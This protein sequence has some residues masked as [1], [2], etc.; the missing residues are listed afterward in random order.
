[1]ITDDL[2]VSDLIL[3]SCSGSLRSPG[4]GRRQWHSV[5]DKSRLIANETIGRNIEIGMGWGKPQPPAC[6]F[7]SLSCHCM[8]PIIWWSLFLRIS[9]TDTDTRGTSYTLAFFFLSTSLDVYWCKEKLAHY[10]EKL[11]ASI[12]KKYKQYPEYTW[13]PT[14]IWD[15]ID[16]SKIYDIQVMT[17]E[18]KHYVKQPTIH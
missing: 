6:G 14:H 17:L 5:V 9:Y 8:S 18:R 10:E 4:D 13:Q 2:V 11:E 7:F 15:N 1:M 12:R 3:K 16:I